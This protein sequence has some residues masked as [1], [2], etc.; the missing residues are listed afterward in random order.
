MQFT[1]SRQL[2]RANLT[3]FTSDDQA[4]SRETVV[5]CHVLKKKLPITATDRRLMI[6]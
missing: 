2:I 3:T 5:D 4:G 1:G 6:R